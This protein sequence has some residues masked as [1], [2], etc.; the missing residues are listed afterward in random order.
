MLFTMPIILVVS[1]VWSV[2]CDIHILDNDG[3]VIDC[4]QMAATAALFCFRR[5]DVTVWVNMVKKLIAFVGPAYI[6]F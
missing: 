1:Q 4:A 5:P 3:N 2:R 6:V